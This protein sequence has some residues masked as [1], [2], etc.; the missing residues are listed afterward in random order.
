MTL[1]DPQNVGQPAVAVVQ[2]RT[3]QRDMGSVYFKA[4]LS[5][6]R[7]TPII[8]AA[9]RRLFW[10]ARRRY[11]QARAALVDLGVPRKHWGV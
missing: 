3:A 9:Q 8:R 6:D 7:S 5:D 1:P 2:A 4:F 11:E 10:Q